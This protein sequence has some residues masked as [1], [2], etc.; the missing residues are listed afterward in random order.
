MLRRYEFMKKSYWKKIGIAADVITIVMGI[1]LL[2]LKIK[3][4]KGE[5]DK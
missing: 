4:M 1:A 3:Q 2:V 5:D